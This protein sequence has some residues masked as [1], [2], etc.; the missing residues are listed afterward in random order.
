MW[1]AIRFCGGRPGGAG[2]GG[3]THVIGRDR[4]NELC[5][6]SADRRRI[7]TSTHFSFRARR[8]FVSYR[9]NAAT[10]NA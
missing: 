6:Q 7:Y 10:I 2:G 4:G 5:L 3:G 9:S 8:A 1:R